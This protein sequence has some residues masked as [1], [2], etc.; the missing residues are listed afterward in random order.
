MRI[1]RVGQLQVHKNIW[2]Y[3]GMLLFV[4][5]VCWSAFNLESTIKITSP[6]PGCVWFTVMMIT[7]VGVL[8]GITIGLTISFALDEAF[9]PGTEEEAPLLTNREYG[10]KNNQNV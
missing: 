1:T 4:F 6:C 2:A 3:L 10:T 7:I 9:K 5:N 8:F